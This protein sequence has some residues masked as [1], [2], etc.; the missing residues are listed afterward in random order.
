[1]LTIRKTRHISGGFLILF[2]WSSF[3]A[4]DGFVLCTAEGHGTAPVSAHEPH[5][6][7]MTPP[8]NGCCESEEPNTEMAHHH[9]PCTGVPV[10][11]DMGQ[12]P[13]PDKL[14]ELTILRASGLPVG[15]SCAY[16]ADDPEPVVQEGSG[17]ELV[18]A[19]TLE[20]LQSVVLII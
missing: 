7:C 12:I 9:I 15:G 1:M 19:S 11:T 16:A 3:A 2:V 6:V 17:F 4:L 8:D 18:P 13:D 20:H 10:G 14:P 5:M